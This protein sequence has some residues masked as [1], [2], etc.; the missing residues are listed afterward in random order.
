ME[1]TR[2][3]GSMGRG[4]D[5]DDS[6]ELDRFSSSD[7]LRLVL[8]AESLKGT[9]LKQLLRREGIS[10]DELDEWR[11]SM[12]WAL[13]GTKERLSSQGEVRRLERRLRRQEKELK[14]AKALLELKKN[15]A[16]VGG[17]GRRH[18]HRATTRDAR[19]HRPGRACRRA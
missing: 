4:H 6:R 16:D 5:D 19:A 15:P 13:E 18:I 2:V 3:A 1:Y 17:R 9:E 8:Q 10:E 7:K 11:G 12:M 14:E